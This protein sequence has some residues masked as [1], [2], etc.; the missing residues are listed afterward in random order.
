M[1]EHVKERVQRWGSIEPREDSHS[2]RNR[3]CTLLV[4]LSSGL[5][6]RTS[7]GYY[8]YSR[9][10]R[11]WGFW[12]SYAPASKSCPMGWEGRRKRNNPLIIRRINGGIWTRRSQSLPSRFMF[13]FG[14]NFKTYLDFSGKGWW[15]EGSLPPQDFLLKAP[16]LWPLKIGEKKSHKTYFPSR[17]F[18][19]VPKSEG[20]G[21]G[22]EELA[23]GY[24][25]HHSHVNA[26]KVIWPLSTSFTPKHRITTNFFVS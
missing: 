23:S 13:G 5:N 2:Q 20:D 9:C 24:H 19:A 21:G 12:L 22:K 10:M 18:K 17:L 8:S 25:L 14:H 16:F 4:L 26:N 11:S 6:F 1:W 15:G 7:L 3:M